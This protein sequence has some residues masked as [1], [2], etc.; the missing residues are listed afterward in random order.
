MSGEKVGFVTEACIQISVRVLDP[1]KTWVQ[2]ALGRE[3]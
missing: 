3:I 2:K 1:A